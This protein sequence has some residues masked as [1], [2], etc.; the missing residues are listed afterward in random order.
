[1]SVA[2]AS[3][4]VEIS[5]SAQVRLPSQRGMRTDDSWSSAKS[6]IQ[7]GVPP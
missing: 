6:G 7:D 2:D 5:R 1:M 4:C 3:D